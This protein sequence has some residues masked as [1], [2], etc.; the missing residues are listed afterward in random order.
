M[1]EPVG[2]AAMGATVG[3][4]VEEA[5]GGTAA[6]AVKVAPEALED[7]VGQEA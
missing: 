1:V 4:A 3:T 6:T 5:M 7:R 2:P